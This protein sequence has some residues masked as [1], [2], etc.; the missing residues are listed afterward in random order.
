[1]DYSPTIS[2][3]L[4]AVWWL[5]PIVLI[6][7]VLGSAW[8]K[9]ATG[10]ALVRFSAHLRLPSE[11]YRPI[12]N[13]TLQTPDGT[14][15]I[16]H[17]VVSR[18]GVF[19]L[20]TKHMKGWI[21]GN[22]YDAQWTQTIFR[23]PFKFQNPLR[24]NYK[25]LQAL[26]AALD[27]PEDVVH[28]VVVF[29]GECTFKSPMPANV[30]RGGAYI[31]FIKSFRQQVIPDAQVEVILARLQAKR[32]PPSF[33]THRQH[34]KNLRTRGDPTAERNCPRCGSRMVLRTAKQGRNA[35]RQFC[36]CSSFPKCK[37]V[38]DVT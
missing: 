8:F 37:A 6:V 31:D 19:V 11:I 13:V 10:E 27:V 3:I 12:H 16:D 30:V 32:L 15:Q 14:T 29:S 36:G 2:P 18:F 28:S 38:Q 26:I 21:F 7:G 24:Q 23:R 33:A 1:M 5:V 22:A 4:R 25:H 34:L 17:I 9:G 20:E 35:G